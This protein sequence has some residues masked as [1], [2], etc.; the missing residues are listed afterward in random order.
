M[1]ALQLQ[2]CTVTLHPV[3]L[4]FVSKFMSNR[5]FKAAGGTKVAPQSTATDVSVAISYAVE[6]E[7]R[8]IC[9]WSKAHRLH[10]VSQRIRFASGI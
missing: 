5:Q 9:T 1:C 10:R 8:R 3:I 6:K 2:F 7:T 4:P